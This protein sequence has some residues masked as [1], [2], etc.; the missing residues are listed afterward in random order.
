M[1][2][3][4]EGQAEEF[5]NLFVALD[6]EDDP[7]SRLDGLESFDFLLV[8]HSYWDHELARLREELAV[9]RRTGRQE[10]GRAR[11]MS[12]ALSETCHVLGNA[13]EVEAGL[14]ALMLD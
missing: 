5:A 14:R 8:G 3:F 13:R 9:G 7:F 6:R 4:L 10:P 2:V 1:A 12:A 11:R